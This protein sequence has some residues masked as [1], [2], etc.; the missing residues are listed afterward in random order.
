[1][2]KLAYNLSEFARL[3]GR[4]RTTLYGAIAAGDLR[5]KK[6]GRNTII[7]ADDGQAYLAALPDAVEAGAIR[8]AA[9]PDALRTA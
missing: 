2:P 9:K 5:A 7:L 6:S 1:M 3:T 4:G 8:A